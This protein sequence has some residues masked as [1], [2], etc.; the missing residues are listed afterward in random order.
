MTGNSEKIV[1][2]LMGQD[3]SLQWDLSPHKEKR[4]LNANAYYW[5]L[6]GK[7]A[8]A[9]HISTARLHNMMLRDVGLVEMIGDQIVTVYL[10]DTDQAEAQAIEAETY[11]LK[12]T[13]KVIQGRRCYMML[14]GSHTFN[15]AEMARLI[16]FMVAEA[17][18]QGIETLTPAELAHM[19]EMEAQRESKHS[20]RT[21]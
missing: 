6:A 8:H 5:Q 9:L 3:K 15:T 7:V 11:H 20:T 19:M 1:L 17:Q 13:T 16:D 2:F 14:R 18:A 10:P 12:P 4:S 21:E